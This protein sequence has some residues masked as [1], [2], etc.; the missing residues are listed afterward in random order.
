MSL[1]VTAAFALAALILYVPANVFPILHVEMYGA[2]SE[3]TVWDGCQ[4]L[5]KDGDVIVAV[6]VFLASICIP[7]LKL[8][9]L[10]FIVITTRLRVS[11]WKMLRTWL[12][13]IIEGVGRWAMLDVFVLAV[14]VSAVKLQRLATIIPGKGLLAFAGVVVLTLFASASFDPQLIWEQDEVGA[15]QPPNEVRK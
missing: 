15:G 4:R 2:T 10:F 6:V 5:Y 3:N 1:H 14:L 8:L 11:R 7:V 9:G 12:F 13:K